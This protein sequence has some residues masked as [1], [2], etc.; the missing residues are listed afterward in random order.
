V[1]SEDGNKEL[2]DLYKSAMFSAREDID[3]LSPPNEVATKKRLS[4]LLT[5]PQVP[6]LL[7]LLQCS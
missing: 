7:S 5:D 6:A 2:E 3:F 4:V 1:G